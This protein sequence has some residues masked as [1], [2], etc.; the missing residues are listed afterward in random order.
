MPELKISVFPSV[1]CSKLIKG[2]RWVV[3]VYIQTE[4]TRGYLLGYNAMHLSVF[5]T[6]TEAVKFAKELGGNVVLNVTE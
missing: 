2:E 6:R 3:G 1:E 5:L 4:W